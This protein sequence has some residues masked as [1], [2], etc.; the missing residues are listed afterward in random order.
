MK[1]FDEDLNDPHSLAGGDADANS[2]DPKR[3]FRDA[4]AAA[5]VAAAAADSEADGGGDV[6]E[7]DGHIA[8]VHLDFEQFAH[9]DARHASLRHLVPSHWDRQEIPFS[10]GK[11]QSR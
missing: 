5:G 4:A 11:V 6:E 8:V 9:R 2:L 3:R 10:G 1:F 7:E